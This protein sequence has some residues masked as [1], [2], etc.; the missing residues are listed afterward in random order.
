M[1]HSNASRP[2]R[3]KKVVYLPNKGQ[4]GRS[5]AEVIP[6]KPASKQS[7]G[8]RTMGIIILGI[9]VVG[10][11]TFPLLQALSDSQETTQTLKD[12]KQAEKEAMQEN[13]QAQEEYKH[14]QDPDYL[15]D[16][17]R[18]DYYYSKPGEIIFELN[19]GQE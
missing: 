3:N 9:V 15:S 12:T 16:V 11:S 19:D 14:M 10:L 13:I 5:M 2:Q 7:F 6:N 18:R 1:Q 8:I 4:R 17:A